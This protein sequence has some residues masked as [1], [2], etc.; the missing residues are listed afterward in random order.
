[1]AHLR[2]RWEIDCLYIVASKIPDAPPPPTASTPSSLSSSSS[3]SQHPLLRPSAQ[4]AIPPLPTVNGTY[5]PGYPLHFS[6]FIPTRTDGSRGRWVT[7]DMPPQTCVHLFGPDR[8]GRVP[9]AIARIVPLPTGAPVLGFND[10]LDHA[11]LPDQTNLTWFLEIISA[12]DA[13]R[14]LECRNELMLL[15]VLEDASDRPFEGSFADCSHVCRPA[16][17]APEH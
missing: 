13:G 5:V 8:E 14:I 1:M 12:L 3:N 4:R 9:H 2:A 16:Q 15:R 6:F 17:G 11:T 10:A 7:Y